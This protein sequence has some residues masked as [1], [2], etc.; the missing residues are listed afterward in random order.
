MPFTHRKEYAT[1]VAEAKKQETRERR[2][3]KV[4]AAL[5]ERRRTTKHKLH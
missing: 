3:E 1:W 5:D 4:L 2:I